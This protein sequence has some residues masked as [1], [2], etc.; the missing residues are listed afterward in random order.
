MSE[1]IKVGLIGIG[2]MGR[3]HFQCYG[4]NPRA[5][6]VAIC[7]VN[8]DKL[9]GDWSSI[10][11][12]LD[13]SKTPRV[14]LSGIVTYSD[15]HQLIADESV[16]LVDI[17]LPTPFH[18]EASIAAL[19]G[20]KHVMCEKPMAM[21]V[22]QC[23]QMAQAASEADR[24]LM[25]GHCLRFW[26]QYVRAH[27]II[28]SGEYGRVLYARFARSSGLPLGSWNHWLET[29]NQSGGVVFDAHIH[30]V[31]VAL[32]WFGRPSQIAA[33]G[34]TRDGLPL[35]IDS[36]WRYDDGKVLALHGS[37]DP[38]GGPFNH[39]FKIVMERATIV[40]DLA[41][42]SFRLIEGAGDD[43]AGRAIEVDD[44]LAYQNELDDYV[45]CLIAGRKMERVSPQG[46]TLAVEIAREELAQIGQKN[47][48]KV[49]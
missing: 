25:I 33:D 45:D 31:D 9:A 48:C 4:A 3:T 39:A 22:E 14:D 15:Y 32:W 23:A 47:N 10:S 43:E 27:E 5:E 7:D 13:T 17:C 12:N 30:D 44:S 21:D 8:E 26:P 24:Q 34:I 42:N 16:Q 18:A 19:R 2:G 37:W 40:H 20:G 29:A 41:T 28:Q 46:S 1:T 35:S 49:F 6:I 36:T 11:L 38:N